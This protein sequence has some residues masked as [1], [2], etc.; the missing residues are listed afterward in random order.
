MEDDN[1]IPTSTWH[2]F[3]FTINEFINSLIGSF[4]TILKIKKDRDLPI[5]T[6]E[7]HHFFGALEAS[8]P[9]M[10]KRYQFR[11]ELGNSME[12]KSTLKASSL[13]VS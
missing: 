8:L 13:A 6:Q 10:S 7:R 5:T 1:L 3:S 4:R 9:A 11:A 12:H 2:S